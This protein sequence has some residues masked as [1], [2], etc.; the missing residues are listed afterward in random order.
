MR[1][2]KRV[3]RVVAA[4]SLAA[5]A[6][7]AV[8]TPADAGKP[9]SQD[10]TT[11]SAYGYN[12]GDDRMYLSVLYD[13]VLKGSP[14]KSVATMTYQITWMD[15]AGATIGTSETSMQGLYPRSTEWYVQSPRPA[16][17][18]QVQATG[19][20]TLNRGSTVIDS[21]DT[22]VQACAGTWTGASTAL[23]SLTDTD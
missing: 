13:T 22:G 23:F 1:S 10:I 12:A 15:E 16:G 4:A 7:L 17:A 11:V 6:M 14:S 20:L 8:A 9:V 18:V 2:I 19:T 5:G 3:T 21:F